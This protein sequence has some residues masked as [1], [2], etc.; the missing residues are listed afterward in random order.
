MNSAMLGGDFAALMAFLA[1]ADQRSFRGGVA[2]DIIALVFSAE[3]AARHETTSNMI[4]VRVFGPLRIAV[5]GA[6]PYSA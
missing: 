4:A 2:P 5:V 1:V 6:P 3:I